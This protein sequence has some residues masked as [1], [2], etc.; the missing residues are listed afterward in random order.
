V[1]Y[2]DEH[3]HLF[4]AEPICRTLTSFGCPIASSTYHATCRRLPSA[5]ARRDAWLAG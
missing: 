5:R 2:I 4:G 3:K 1:S